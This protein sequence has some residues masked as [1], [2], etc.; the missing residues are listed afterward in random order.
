MHMLTIIRHGIVKSE[1]VSILLGHCDDFCIFLS[2]C[3]HY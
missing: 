2:P 1:I 3:V